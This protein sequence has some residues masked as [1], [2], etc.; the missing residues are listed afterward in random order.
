MTKITLKQKLYENQ[1]QFGTWCILPN[2]EVVSV[3]TGSG[4]DYVLIDF[5]H[6][7]VSF[8]TAQKMVMASHAQ[9]KYAVSRVGKLEEV[10]ILRALDIKSDGIIVPHI[11]SLEDVKKVVSYVKYYPD[12]NRGY[13]PYTYAGGYNVHKDYTK[14]AND[15][16]LLGIIIESQKGV[17][18][19][20]EILSSPDLDLVYLGAYDISI[21]LG[22]AGQITH[23]KVVEV[24]DYCI[25]K[26]IKAGKI[27]GAMYHSQADYEQFKKQGVNFLVYK[28]DSLI[29]NEGL[30]PVR[31]VK[32]E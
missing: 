32:G 15:N 30:A 21:S 3:L 26:I 23:P 5:E 9:N 8:E 10:E 18:N 14:N 31:D 22:L 11:E 29:I 16:I 2:P 28:V 20:D 27:A 13:S 7:P 1:Q 24:L 19:L 4:L 12:G 25:E 6:S 17:D